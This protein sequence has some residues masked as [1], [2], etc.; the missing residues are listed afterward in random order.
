MQ[1]PKK[2]VSSKEIENFT[3][4]KLLSLS[5]ETIA[6][7][8]TDIDANSSSPTVYDGDNLV[9]EAVEDNDNNYDLLYGSSMWSAYMNTT[10]GVFKR[11][12]E[13]LS[14]SIINILEDIGADMYNDGSSWFYKVANL[15]DPNI[16]YLQKHSELK[17]EW[18]LFLKNVLMSKAEYLLV[19]R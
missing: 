16:E 6:L 15:M 9:V 1:I 14:Q 7:S 18:E 13:N 4:A 17:D 2:L 12:T 3:Q 19:E 5:D 11:N 8:L 10:S